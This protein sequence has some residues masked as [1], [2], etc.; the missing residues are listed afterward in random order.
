[1]LSN[2]LFNLFCGTII[3]MFIK[4]TNCIAVESNGE[5]TMVKRGFF[6][7]ASVTITASI[8]ESD[9]TTVAATPVNLM[10]THVQCDGG[11]SHRLVL[12]GSY[13]VAAVF[14]SY[15]LAYCCFIKHQVQSLSL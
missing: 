6:A 10:F 5:Y 7:A 12:F 3:S 1:M 15:A 13:T 9:T 8:A 14:I 11:F 2:L 4:I